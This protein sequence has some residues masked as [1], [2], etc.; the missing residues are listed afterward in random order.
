MWGGT[1]LDSHCFSDGRR[2][3]K[4]AT[5]VAAAHPGLNFRASAAEVRGPNLIINAT[6]C[7]LKP[8]TDPLPI[9]IA[10]LTPNMMVA[11]IV[12][13]PERTQLLAAAER[14][15]CAVRFAAGMLDSQMN[16]MARFFGY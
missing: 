10:E 11:D 3:E 16:L 2:A 6:P 5:M 13:K 14:A 12:M 7:G 1:G 4:L 9:D 8:H 15:G